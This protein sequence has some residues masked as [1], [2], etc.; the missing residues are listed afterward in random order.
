MKQTRGFTLLEVMVAVA[1]LGLGLT[2]ILSGQ[3]AA[4]SASSQAR[5][6]S[7]AT[8]LLRCK[9]SEIEEQLAKEGF[10]ELDQNESGACCEDDDSAMTCT[11]KIE[12][13]ELPEPS[14]GDLDLDSDLDL[15]GGGLGALGQMSAIDQG[16]AS[17]EPGSSVG[18]IASALTGSAGGEGSAASAMAGIAGMVMNMVYPDLKGVFEASARRVTVTI[19]WKQGSQ[20]HSI[21]LVQWITNPKQG[22]LVGEIPGEDAAIDQALGG[23]TPTDASQ[24]RGTR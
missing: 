3:A 8:T 2:A 11:W 1:I 12:K 23:A 6:M 7:V 15:A 16:K 17:L 10:Q 19:T 24:K 5:H 9:M 13:P 14:Y 22:G 18:D 21:D 20:E 4:F